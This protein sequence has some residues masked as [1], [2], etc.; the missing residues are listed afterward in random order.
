MLGAGLVDVAHAGL[1]HR[2]GRMHK[3]SAVSKDLEDVRRC[4]QGDGDAYRRLIERH[5]G[6]I[7]G[8]MWR[9]SR[10]ADVHAD[11]VQDVF[12]E[13]Y[14][15][16][17]NYRGTAPFEHWLSR[18]ATHVG[19]Q[20]W[21]RQKRESALQ[22]VPLEDWH[23]LAEDPPEEIDPTEAAQRLHQLL[24]QLPPRDRLVLTLRYVEDRSVE[25]TAAMTGWSQTMVKVQTWRAKRKLRALFERAG[26]G[27]N[28]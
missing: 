15:G 26:Q 13:A 2:A 27:A 4:L 9:F 19:Y 6:R 5:Q 10:D 24:E 7:S 20:H 18:V 12:V 16:L 14:R 17:R 3:A 21:K 1:V 23:E 25:Q 22:M 8:M 11:L 28:Q